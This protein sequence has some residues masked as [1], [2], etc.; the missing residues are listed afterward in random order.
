VEVEI[1]GGVKIA[2]AAR[3]VQAGASV[4]VVASGIFHEPDP[5]EAAR[6]IAEIAREAA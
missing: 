4:L 1:D 6:R 2:N 3:A 5:A